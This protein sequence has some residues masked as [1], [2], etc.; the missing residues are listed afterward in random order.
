MKN[1][2]PTIEYALKDRF[3]YTDA[4]FL[5]TA[6]HWANQNRVWSAFKRLLDIDR[7]TVVYSPLHKVQTLLAS[8]SVGC[9][10]S[11]MLPTP[12][13][14]G[15]SVQRRGLRHDAPKG[16]PSPLDGPGR[17]RIPVEDETAGGADG[18]A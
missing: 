5:V 15:C 6:L 10:F 7:K 17:V 1:T 18:G 14:G 16:P 3:D 13:G 11:D 9:Q 4:A 8:I 12:Q 2:I